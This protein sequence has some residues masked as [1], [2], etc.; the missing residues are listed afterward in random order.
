[1]DLAVSESSMSAAAGNQPLAL[2]VAAL[3]VLGTLVL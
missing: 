3:A 1:V 2:L